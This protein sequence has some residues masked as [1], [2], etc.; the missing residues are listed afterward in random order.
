MKLSIAL[1]FAMISAA[2]AQLSDLPTCAKSCATDAIP[3]SCGVDVA[4]ICK[5]GTF[6]ADVACCIVGV[7]TE[8]EQEETL[9]VAD[10]ICSAG[11]VTGLPTTVACTTGASATGDA[12]TT[13]TATGTD[14]TSTSTA[15]SK[16]TSTKETTSGT[17]ATSATDAS[18][19]STATGAAAAV[20]N[21]EASFMAA[22]AVGL[23]AFL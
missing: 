21:K 4:C 23:A 13:A 8:E 14:T 11:G 2:T 17:S 1:A 22:A 3:A 18:A 12:T 10:E 15:S 16:S 9:K 7:C 20:Q 6:I 5:S 19:T